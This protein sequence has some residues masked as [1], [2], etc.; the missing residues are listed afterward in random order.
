MNP[1]L[2][3]YGSLFTRAWTSEFV[4]TALRVIFGALLVYHGTSKVFEGFDKMAQDLAMLGWPLPWLQAM[5]AA[6][7]EFAG[8]VVIMVGLLTRPALLAVIAQFTIIV[9]IYSAN[10]PFPKKEKAL[11]FLII[12]VLLFLVGPGRYSVDARLFETK[13]ANG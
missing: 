11:V 1:S 8:G 6:Y 7:I 2:Q 5:L 4:F 3:R 12:A 10:D 9:F 13:D